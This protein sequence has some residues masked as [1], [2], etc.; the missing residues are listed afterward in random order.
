MKK[1]ERKAEAVTGQAKK[2]R[3]KVDGIGRV[4]WYYMKKHH[5]LKEVEIAQLKEATCPAK[6]K[7]SAATLVRIFNPDIAKEKGITVEDYE[8]LNEQPE[9]I[10]YEGYHIPGR[11]GEIIIEKREAVGTSLLDKKIKEGAITE[12]GVIQEKT[13]R[14]KWLGRIGNFMVMGGFILV[15]FLVVAIIVAVSFLSK[16]C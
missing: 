1:E 2:T 11:G 16:G 8:S 13:A 10:I 6:V 4:A 9:L 7:D 5:G 15:I 14:Q 12:V 3:G